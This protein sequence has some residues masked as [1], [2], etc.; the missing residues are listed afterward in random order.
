[1]P[2]AWIVCHAYLQNFAYHTHL[3]WWVFAASGFIMV[4]IAMATIGWHTVKA[5]IANPVDSLRTE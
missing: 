4:A 2:L 1:M 3:D 5:A